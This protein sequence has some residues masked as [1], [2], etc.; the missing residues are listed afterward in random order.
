MLNRL[1]LVA[2]FWGSGMAAL[3]S[4]ALVMTPVSMFGD[5]DNQMAPFLVGLGI[6]APIVTGAV[7]RWFWSD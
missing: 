1:I 3:F 2:K 4:T 5:T 7:Q 6:V